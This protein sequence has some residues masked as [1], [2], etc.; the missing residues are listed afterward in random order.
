MQQHNIPGTDRVLLSATAQNLQA[1]IEL[2]AQHSLGI[3]LMTFAFPDVLDSD[4]QRLVN[5]YKG[6][7]EPVRGMITMHGPFMDMAPG[8]PDRLVNDICMRRYQHAIHIAQQLGVETIVFHANFIASIQTEVYRKGWQE[9]N[10]AFWSM[11]A[12]YA[13]DHDVVIAVENMWEFDPYIIGDVLRAVDHSHLRACID[14]GHAHL[15]SDNPFD[16]WLETMAPFVVHTHMNNNDGVTD[17]H[18]ALS[19]G[20]LDYPT[21]LNKLRALPHRPTMTLEMDKVEDMAASLP[22]FHLPEAAEHWRQREPLK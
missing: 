8:S 3:E 5:T 19:N 21:L 7:L 4:W 16:E 22:Y 1:C 14:V 6:L 13:R 2:A 18:R 15:F 10:I 20:V 17:Y 12:S 9:R 11:M